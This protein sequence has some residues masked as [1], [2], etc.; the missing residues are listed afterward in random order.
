MVS[1][2]FMKLNLRNVMHI[3]QWAVIYSRAFHFNAKSS[4]GIF[5]HKC[6]KCKIVIY[7]LNP[8][9]LFSG[10]VPRTLNRIEPEPKD[11]RYSFKRTI[12]RCQVEC[13]YDFIKAR[14]WND[15]HQSKDNDRYE[16]FFLVI[17]ADV[18]QPGRWPLCHL[19]LLPFS[20]PSR[21]T[22]P[23][24]ELQCQRVR[25]SNCNFRQWIT[26]SYL[27]Y[28]PHQLVYCLTFP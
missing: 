1:S 16:S 26:C 2:F 20:S 13:N 25:V 4:D 21:I 9:P 17:R 19:I 10:F 27:H 15:F 5:D 8:Y 11:I 18:T 22:W 14:P 6:T 3:N 28:L 23:N 7:A 24:F 12:Q